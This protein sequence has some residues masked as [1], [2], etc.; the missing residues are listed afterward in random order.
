MLLLEK[1]QERGIVLSP[2]ER[3]ALELHVGSSEIPLAPKTSAEFLALFLNG[4]TT[5]EI[6]KLNPGFKLGIIV[7]A[8]IE[9]EWDRHKQE[10]VDTLL[11]QTRETVQK[12][13]LEA[14][15][16]ASDG[17]TVYH[18]VLG[19]AFKKF[20]QSGKEEDLGKANLDTMNIKTYR[21]YVTLLR[22]LTGQDA[23]KQ[24]SGEIVHTIERSNEKTIDAAA[25][26]GSDL[27]KVLE[28]VASGK[29]VE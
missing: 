21:E 13:Q 3:G 22:E 28:A 20:L 26:D 2:R 10:Y 8:R 15:R 16:F 14:I 23:K 6:Q 1:A 5:E 25:A 18:R 24:V 19:A 4:Y 17:M 9:H 27:L 12:T 7:H 29:K 11:T